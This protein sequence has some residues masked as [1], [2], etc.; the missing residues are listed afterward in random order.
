MTRTRGGT[1]SL[2]KNL[3]EDEARATLQRLR[4]PLDQ[5]GPWSDWQI[6][7]E[8]QRRLKGPT[9]W[10]SGSYSPSDG[11]LEQIE[12]WGPPDETLV[13]WPKPDDYD[14]RVARITAEEEARAASEPPRPSK[15][16]PEVDGHDEPKAGAV[17]P[18]WRGKLKGFL[19]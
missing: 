2:I 19:K 16:S 15:Q 13:V 17:S 9:S 7:A 6:R 12:C 5:G 8:V 1:V 18:T 10:Y 14:E 3:T 4:R 11:D